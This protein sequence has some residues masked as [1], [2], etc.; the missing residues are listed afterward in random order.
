MKILAKIWLAN[1][2]QFVLSQ[3]SI[4]TL[5][6]QKKKNALSCISFHFTQV[7]NSKF[8]GIKKSTKIQGSWVHAGIEIKLL[9]QV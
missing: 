3:M 2:F 4:L 7:T 5:A 6:S 1:H 9:G 8:G